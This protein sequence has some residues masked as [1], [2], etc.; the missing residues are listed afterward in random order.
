VGFYSKKDQNYIYATRAS[1]KCVKVYER[2]NFD[3]P[4]FLEANNE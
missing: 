4:E 1:K 2:L 3:Q